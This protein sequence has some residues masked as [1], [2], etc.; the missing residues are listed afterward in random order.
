MIRLSVTFLP[1]GSR[2]SKQLHF[3]KSRFF[4]SNEI[5]RVNSS[6]AGDSIVQTHTAV[7]QVFAGKRKLAA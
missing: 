6:R 3:G 5:V 7:I 4:N 2:G 1:V